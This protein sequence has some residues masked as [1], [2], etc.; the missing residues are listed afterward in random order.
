VHALSEHPSEPR[1]RRARTI[2]TA[3]LLA[4]FALAVYGMFIFT[5]AQRSQGM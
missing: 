5:M 1:Q 3:V 4:I 2:R